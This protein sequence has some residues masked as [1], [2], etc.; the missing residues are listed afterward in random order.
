MIRN[1]FIKHELVFK[2]KDKLYFF[3]NILGLVT[4]LQLLFSIFIFVFVYI[5]YNHKEHKLS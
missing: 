5:W 1:N 3:N 4:F 2:G